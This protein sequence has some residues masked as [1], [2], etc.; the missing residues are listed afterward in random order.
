MVENKTEILSQLEQLLKMT[1][2][3]ETLDYIE[4]ISADHEAVIRFKSGAIYT[5]ST[6]GTGI[7]LIDR[8]IHVGEKKKDDVRKHRPRE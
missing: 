7:M 3:W 5:V 2:N 4:Y 1:D 6:D 8:I